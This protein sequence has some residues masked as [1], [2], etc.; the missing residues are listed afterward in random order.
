[1]SKST[2]PSFYEIKVQLAGYRDELN[3]AK[4]GSKDFHNRAIVRVK[5]STFKFSTVA[6]LPYQLSSLFPQ[7]LLLVEKTRKRGEIR[8]SGDK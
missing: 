6:N 2:F 5:T 8:E 3:R 4:N 1:M 7:R